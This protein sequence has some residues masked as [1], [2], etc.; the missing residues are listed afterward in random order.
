MD[1]SQ[2][3]VAGEVNTMEVVRPSTSFPT[4]LPMRERCAYQ[5]KVMLRRLEELVPRFMREAELDT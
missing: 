3:R 1:G 4:I 5:E 2:L